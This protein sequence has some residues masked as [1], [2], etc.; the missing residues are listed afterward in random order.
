MTSDRDSDTASKKKKEEEKNEYSERGLPFFPPN[1]EII[2]TD[3]DKNKFRFLLTFYSFHYL[4]S[5]T[6]IFLFL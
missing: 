5:L 1:H 2:F 3:N 4:W 6:C